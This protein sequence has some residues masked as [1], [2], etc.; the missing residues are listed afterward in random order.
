MSR[1]R[2]SKLRLGRKSDLFKPLTSS[3][4]PGN[5]PASGRRDTR[6]CVRTDSHALRHHGLI[7]APSPGLDGP[8][9][10]GVGVVRFATLRQPFLV[11]NSGTERLRLQLLRADP[12]LPKKRLPCRLIEILDRALNSYA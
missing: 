4:A 10:I 9:A 3:L 7:P 12:T 5:G 11:R 8:V 1:S 2:I 6:G